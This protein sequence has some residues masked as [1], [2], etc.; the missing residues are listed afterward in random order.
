MGG[1]GCRGVGWAV[2]GTG[3]VM[4][5]SVLGGAVT[6]AGGGVCVLAC[7]AGGS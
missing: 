5:L 3:V 6:V 4:V 7:G 1:G 2:K